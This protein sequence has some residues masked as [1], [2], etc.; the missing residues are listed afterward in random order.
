MIFLTCSMGNGTSW[1]G[2]AWC[3]HSPANYVGEE[4]P[5]QLIGS[6]VRAFN[7]SFQNQWV[8]KN[9]L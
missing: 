2:R 8:L 1:T 5:D 6:L 7:A 4:G 9:I 3:F